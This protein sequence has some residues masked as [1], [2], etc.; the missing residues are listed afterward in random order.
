MFER[1]KKLR[2]N[3]YSYKSNYR[4][5]CIIQMKDGNIF[6]GVNVE[7]PSFKDGLCA[8]QVAIGT[9]IAKGYTKN[10]FETLYLLGDSEYEITPCFLCRQLLIEFFEP[11]KLVIT[12]N[13]KGKEKKYKISELCPHTFSEKEL[14]K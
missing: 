14:E 3:S 8:E 13:A 6:E 5:A 7:N 4:V 9:A 2:E 1:L 10:D 11:T 12:Y